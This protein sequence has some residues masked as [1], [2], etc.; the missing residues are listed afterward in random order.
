MRR[1]LIA[2]ILLGMFLSETCLANENSTQIS[3]YLTV[4]NKPKLSQIDLLAQIVQ[5]RFPRSIQTIGDAMN[6]LLS[7]SGYSLVP[8]T[9][10]NQELR[11]TIHKPLPLVDREFGP[12]SLKDG[13]ITLMGPAFYMTNDPVNRI[14][15]FRLKVGY[16]KFIQNKKIQRG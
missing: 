8:E 4:S 3:R 5:V 9:Q 13:L 12:M 2:I 1:K 10:M 14:V 11:I 16:E 7:F 6:Y 15:N